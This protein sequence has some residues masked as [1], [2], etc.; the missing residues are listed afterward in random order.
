MQKKIYFQN[1]DAI[2]FI[3]ALMVFLTHRMDQLYMLSKINCPFLGKLWDLISCGYLGV[4]MFFVL[5]GF[6]ITFILLEEKELTNHINVKNFYFRR[7]LRIWPLY[8]LILLISFGIIPWVCHL[9]DII[10]TTP[11]RLPYYLTFLSNF[12]LLHQDRFQLG[13]GNGA[14]VLMQILT[15]SVSVEEQ[16]YLVWPLLFLL[17]K[18]RYY[19]F[20]F[21]FAIIGS[22]AFRLYHYND[23]LILAYHTLSNV[24][25]LAIGGLSA[26]L[27]LKHHS[28]KAFFS[29]IPLW[30]SLLV[31]TLGL[32]LLLYRDNVMA[33]SP[34]VWAFIPLLYA[35]FFAFVLLHQ[36][37][38]PDS[39]LK[40]GKY[41]FLSFW[42][43]Y[44][45]GIYL[46]HPVI[47]GGMKYII[48]RKSINET[49]FL[50]YLLI[51]IVSLAFTL[52]LSYISYELFEKRFLKLKRKFSVI[53]RD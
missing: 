44:S 28:V 14:V 53:V 38:A 5:S 33:L 13:K 24:A 51:G 11:G 42:G 12:D 43:K 26:Y 19:V 4:C 25:A 52:A 10:N 36:N 1:L 17:V 22:I 41:K 48:L 27:T 21:V 16:F 7:V 9:T 31:Y 39:F 35:A 15:W 50:N 8:F 3:A 23:G 47:M 40:L 37:F 6:L 2:R 18:P 46:L 30:A 34:Y 32:A 45:Y 29:K 49:N 20:I